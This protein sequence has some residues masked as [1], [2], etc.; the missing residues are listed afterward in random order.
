MTSLK[1]L[2][3]RWAVP[4]LIRLACVVSLTALGLTAASILYP[5]PLLVM[6]ASSI[7]QVLILVALG[8]YALAVLADSLRAEKRALAPPAAHDESP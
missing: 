8:L 3:G 5:R 7:G 4:V 1:L 2:L 6:A